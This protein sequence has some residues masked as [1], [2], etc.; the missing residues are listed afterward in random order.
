MKNGFTLIE[1]ILT[2]IIVGIIALVSAQVLMRGIETYSL[3]TNRKD[4][5]QHARVGMDRM[6]QELMLLKSL[7]LTYASD[8]RIDFFDATGALTNFRRASVYSTIDLFRRDDFL[9]GRISLLDFD[10]YRS[11]DAATTV[12]LAVRRINIELTTQTIG[13][14]GTVPVRTNVFPRNFMYTNFR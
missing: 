1:L 4:A 6:I 9:A 10:F 7:D 12:P 8:A 13:G 14:Y 2:I 3:V 5:T 11:N